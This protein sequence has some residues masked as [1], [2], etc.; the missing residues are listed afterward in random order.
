M[1]P[2]AQ[3]G[4]IDEVALDFSGVKP[5]EAMDEGTIYLCSTDSLKLGTSKNQNPKASLVATIVAPDEAPVAD[6]D[7]SNQIGVLD[8]TTKAKN[9]KLF[10]EFSLLPDAL[11]FLYEYVKAVDPEVVLDENFVLKTKEYTGLRFACKIKNREYEGTIRPDIKRI[12]P[13]SAFTG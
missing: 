2:K 8:R 12:L 9:R 6:F 10:R 1:S 7:G 3:K 4:P 13:E 5:F 11:P